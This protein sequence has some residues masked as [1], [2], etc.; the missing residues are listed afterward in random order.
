MKTF[1]I[2]SYGGCGSKM[3]QESLNKYGKPVYVRHEIV[4]NK[5]LCHI[6]L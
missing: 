1:Y 6:Y 5:H 2:C 4:H 3:L